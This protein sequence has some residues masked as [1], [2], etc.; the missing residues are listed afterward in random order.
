MRVR[1]SARPLSRLILTVAVLTFAVASLALSAAQSSAQNATA[2]FDVVSIKVHKSGVGSSETLARA[3]GYVMLSNVTVR[4]LIEKAYFPYNTGWSPSIS[5]LI[6]GTLPDWA[7]SEHFDVEATASGNPTI[8]QKQLMLKSMLEDRFKLAVHHETR[9]LSVFA[10]VVAKSGKTG[11]QLMPHAKGSCLEPAQVGHASEAGAPTM[12][13][14]MLQA[15][16]ERNGPS[17]IVLFANGITMPWLAENLGGVV[18]RMIVDQTGLNGTFDFTLAFTPEPGQP[19]AP[20][21][22]DAGPDA[23]SEPSIFTAM[24]EQLGLKLEPRTEPVDILV[25]DHVEEPSAN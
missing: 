9:Q 16:N 1:A 10:L 23:S 24:Q 20:R 19:G 13:C 25:V 3:G 15:R 17:S 22:T 21:N 12:I 14:D 11:P 8:A 6:G 18:R 4:Q 7:A 2:T 5:F